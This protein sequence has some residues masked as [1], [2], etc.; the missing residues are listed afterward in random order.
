MA[1]IEGKI[2]KI[3][4]EYNVVINVGR[5]QGVCEG[6]PFV[7][8]I[9]GEDEV[10]DPDTG[11]GLGRLETVKGYVSAAHVQDRVSICTVHPLTKGGVEGE[12]KVQT[13][14]GA[15]MAESLGYRSGGEQRLNVNPSQVSG[16]AR[17]GPISIGDGVRSLGRVE[18]P[19]E[20]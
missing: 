18:R 3:L 16:L 13:L 12:V 8:F 4:D 17:G 10:K 9:T 2:A 20:D 6:M 11:E 15:M 1:P 19:I 7:I 5:K 14:S